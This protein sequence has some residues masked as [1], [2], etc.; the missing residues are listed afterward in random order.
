MPTWKEKKTEEINQEEAELGQNGR[1][2]E[3][4]SDFG[5][6]SEKMDAMTAV[7]LTAEEHA[8]VH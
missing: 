8:Q 3:K 5:S 1:M 7:F 2:I 6:P 4:G